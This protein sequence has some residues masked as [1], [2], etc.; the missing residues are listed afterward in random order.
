MR[1]ALVVG[2]LLTAVLFCYYGVNE[3]GAIPFGVN[4]GDIARQPLPPGIVVQMLKDNGITRVKLFDASYD[5]LKSLSGT[6]I[7]VMVAAPND[8]LAS[9]AGSQKAANA[10]VAENVTRY[11]I[12]GG[13]DIRYVAV[14]NEP[15][16]LAYNGTY[17]NVTLP[18]LQNIQ[19][20]LGDAGLTGKVVATI[21]FNADVLCGPTVNCQS[22]S[23]GVF[24]PDIAD[25]MVTVVG[26]L[27]ASGAPFCQNV[28]PFLSLAL[29]SDFP[30]EYAFFGNYVL[31][32]VTGAIY[33][34][35]FDA[36]YD[37]LVAALNGAGFPNM[38]IIIGEIGWPTDGNDFANIANAQRFN[39]EVLQHLAAKQGT[40]LRPN[41]EFDVYLFSLLDENLKSILPGDFERHWGIFYG[42]G[43][44][45]Y[46]LDWT[47]NGSA[48]WP[49]PSVGVQ[50]LP[51]MWCVLNPSALIDPSILQATLDYACSRTDCTA[52]GEGGSCFLLDNNT[53]ASYAFNNYFQFN[54]QD[55]QACDFQGLAMIT[56]DDPSIAQCK[57]QIGLN[58]KPYDTSSATI[59]RLPG[60][61]GGSSPAFFVVT[62]I[63]LL[64]FMFA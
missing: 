14:G 41:E 5:V 63:F 27:N 19:Q 42:D 9:I 32:D 21:P 38:Q 64:F 47:G 36:S 31:T 39:Q 18:A 55:P 3:S 37:T 43:N 52:I 40:P 12:P 56:S 44:P 6:G 4:W 13:P 11:M 26:A 34:N 7:E 48:V 28:Y 22:P 8:M 51:Q 30:Q 25:L 20:A 49:K 35:V 33:H 15:F 53:R 45:K 50:Y 24:R 16:L 60:K 2:L 1:Q 46:E 58:Y 29:S 61:F 62:L 57:F 10:W 59:L 17:Q 23:Q 54:Y